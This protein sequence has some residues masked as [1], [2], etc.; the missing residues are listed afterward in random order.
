[1]KEW[2]NK[3][4]NKIWMPYVIVLGIVL[5]LEVF[6][7]NFSTWKTMGCEPI[8]LAEQV[9]T[10]ADGIFETEMVTVN[11]DVKNVNVVLKIHNFDRAQVTVSLTDAGDYYAYDMPAYTVVPDVDGCG[12]QNIY[13]FGEVGD[14]KVKVTVPEGAQASIDYIMINSVRP[15]Q[16]RFLRVLVLFVVLAVGNALFSSCSMT[17]IPCKRGDKKQLLIMAAVVFALVY[18]AGFLVRSNPICVLEPWLH[19]QQYQELARSLEQGTVVIDSNPAPELINHRNPYDTISLQVEGI[20]YRAD[21]AYYD[22]N[23]YSYFG[24]IPEVF[25][26]LPYYLLK[27]QDMYNYMA[28]FA[29]YCGLL[30]GVFGTLW[31]VVHRYAKKASYVLYLLLA[32]SVSL[33]SGY[34]FILGRPDIY[35][36]PVMAGNT[37]LWLGLFFW[38]RALNL[39]KGRWLWCGLG[40]FS[41]ACI[42]GCRPQ[43]ILYGIAFFVLLMLPVIWEK[44]KEW[45]KYI[46]EMIAFVVP[47]VAIGAL[48]FWYNHARFGSGFD[49][50]ATYSLTTN[51]MNNRGFNF[52][53][54]LRG[55]YNFLFQPP[56][57]NA[58]FPFLDSAELASDY[59]GK[60]IV[61]F[62]YGG[63]FAI[64]PLLLSLLYVLLG[65]FKTLRTE[66]KRFF[67]GFS[68]VSFVIAAFDINAAGILQRYMCDMVG[69]F[70]LAAVV[71]VFILLDRYKDTNKYIWVVKGTYGCVIMGLAF[72]F[73]IWI[74]SGNNICLENYNPQL[75]YTLAEYFKF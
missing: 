48:V 36:I 69:G 75:F 37:F 54:I 57:I 8:V 20:S 11:D 51:D 49:F 29:L 68:V 45:K 59:M 19:H 35:N 44:K 71:I 73:L 32:I 12:Y 55:L 53:R 7:F 74:T 18:M 42:M 40:S 4:K 67:V 70:V 39:E 2:L 28:V 43:M 63:I 14:I 65:G 27:N 26:F 31:E 6:V 17:R 24:I 22:G 33:L 9:E 72:S 64:Y 50:G 56:V 3:Q 1:L 61:E 5:C 30:V 10:D 13:P 60:N 47:F 58:A 38:L 46:K 15:F 25:L 16:F 62:T 34:V 52:A 23:Y 21:Y 41:I 66:E